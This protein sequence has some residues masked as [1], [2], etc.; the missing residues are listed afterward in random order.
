MN[1]SFLESWRGGGGGGEMGGE[2]RADE[3]EVL[4]IVLVDGVIANAAAESAKPPS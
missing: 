1:W 3:H 2:V 4:K